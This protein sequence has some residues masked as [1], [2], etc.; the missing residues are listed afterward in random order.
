MGVD[1]EVKRAIVLFASPSD[2]DLTLEKYGISF[3]EE[4]R[5]LASERLPER[6]VCSP[7]PC[8]TEMVWHNVG[9]EDAQTLPLQ[10]RSVFF[11]LLLFALCLGLL[12][13][14]LR[15]AYVGGLDEPG[16]SVLF[17][18]V[19]LLLAVLGQVFRYVMQVFAAWTFP[20]THS[21]KAL[22]VVVTTVL[23]HFSFYLF[24]P[25][26]FLLKQDQFRGEVLKI[27]AHQTTNFIIIQLV[28]F[29]LDIRYFLWNR[30]RRRWAGDKEA[31]GCQ[32]VLHKRL[33]YPRFPIEIRLLVL[34]KFWFLMTFFAFHTPIVVFFLL[35]GLLCILAKDKFNIYHHYRMECVRS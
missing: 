31:R 14:G 15:T 32:K 34:F 5:H 4:A 26:L 19:M 10:L 2:R 3:W 13:F 21:Q 23:F 17:F 29:G 11:F 16:K 28:L 1:T 7:C 25:S 6:V 9:Q 8:P 33:Q 27:I 20:Y 22:F 24:L 12:F 18:T 30:R 35:V